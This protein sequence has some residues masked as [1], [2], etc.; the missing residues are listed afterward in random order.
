ME[1]VESSNGTFQVGSYPRLSPWKNNLGGS[2]KK[3]L[4]GKK[5]KPWG[6]ET[7]LTTKKGN[8]WKDGSKGGVRGWKIGAPVESSV[9]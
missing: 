5:F 9:K 2:I 7:W 8:W 4:R 3:K 6:R 1:D